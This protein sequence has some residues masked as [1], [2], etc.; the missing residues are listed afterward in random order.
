MHEVVFLELAGASDVELELGGIAMAEN[1]VISCWCVGEDGFDVGAGEAGLKVLPMMH[2]SGSVVIRADVA[3]WL[4][5]QLEECNVGKEFV[6]RSNYN[7][8]PDVPYMDDYV[9]VFNPD[10][11]W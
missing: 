6:K 11:L 8:V 3:A 10:E 9:P 7:E 2:T 1:V 5:E 4:R